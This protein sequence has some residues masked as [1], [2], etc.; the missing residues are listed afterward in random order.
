MRLQYLLQLG[1]NNM[2]M[3][4]SITIP[5]DHYDNNYNNIVGHSGENIIVRHTSW[6][7]NIHPIK[8]DD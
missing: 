8:L 4:H 7:N 3:Y 6:L 2:Y 1:S 5:P